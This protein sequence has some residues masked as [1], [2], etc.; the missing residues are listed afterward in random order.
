MPHELEETGPLTRTATVTIPNEEFES[1]I[2]DA[3]RELQGNVDVSGFRQGK[4]PFS[5]LR[6]RYGDRV[7][8]DV[9]QSLIRENIS[10]IAQDFEDRLLHVGQ[11]DV[12][13]FPD[14]DDPLEFE[15]DFELKPDLDPVGYLGM[16][17][18]RPEPEVS[19]EEVDEQLEELREEFATLE[20]IELRNE[21]REGDMVT[22]DFE[23]VGDDEALEDFAAQDVET[24]V[25]AQQIL[26]PIERGLEGAELNSTVTVEIED[27]DNL[28]LPDFDGDDLSVEID[29]KSVKQKN[30]PR[31]DDEFAKDTGQAETLLDLRSQIREDIRD[32]KQ[33]RANHL[34]TENLVD[35][36]VEQNDFP[37]PPKFLEEQVDDEIE[38]RTEMFEQ[39][40][41]DPADI[42]ADTEEFREETREELEESLKEE[43]LL[44]AIADEEGLEVEEEDIDNFLEHQAQH[45]Q[46]FSAEQLKQFMQQNEEQWQN[47]QYQALLEKTKTYLL[48]EAET[49]PAPWP[50]EPAHGV[51][52]ADEDEQDDEEASDQEAA[53]DGDDQSDDD[54][55]ESTD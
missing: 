23:A 35:K 41:L 26:P 6:Q 50:D 10:E 11:T 24:E 38:R 34:A 46:R 47:V 48:D 4:V 55:E 27:D 45:D 21:I 16:T 17:V 22:F 9:V 39:Q 53:D 15:V 25:G 19:D 49:E 1:R 51:V 29:I 8:P 54:A 12:T 36:L 18:E 44:T 5:V 32:D 13:N 52:P 2:N 43:F 3:L 37:I 33:H 42:G 14:D 7:I 40:G 30:L 31:L 28:P 20:P